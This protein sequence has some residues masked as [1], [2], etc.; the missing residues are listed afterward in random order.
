[1]AKRYRLID[2]LTSDIMFEAEGKDLAQVFESAAEAMFTIICDIK[3]VEAKKSI[4]ISLGGDNKKDLMINWLQHL[5]GLVDTEEMFFSRFKVKKIDGKHMEA[6]IKGDSVRPELGGTV[7][8]AVT[9]YKYDFRKTRKG[10]RVRVSLD[11]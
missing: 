5:I 6:E 11:I 9:Y 7:V 8:K 3:S 2:D 10:Y 1:M 4:E